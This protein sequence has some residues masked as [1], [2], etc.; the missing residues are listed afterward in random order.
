VSTRR[1]YLIKN[2]RARAEAGREEKGQERDRGRVAAERGEVGGMG[3]GRWR[4][5][6]GSGGCDAGSRGSAPFVTTVLLPD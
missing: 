6:G 1:T 5:G 3:I 2:L 4:R